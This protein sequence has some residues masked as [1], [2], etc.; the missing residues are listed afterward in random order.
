[1]FVF[2][3]RSLPLELLYV[4]PTLF[5][6]FLEQ[7]QVLVPF[8]PGLLQPAFYYM[9]PHGPDA[10]A[11]DTSLRGFFSPLSFPKI[12]VV[13]PSRL[14]GPLLPNDSLYISFL[15]HEHGWTY[16]QGPICFPVPTPSSRLR[17]VLPGL[18]LLPHPAGHAMKFFP[19][20]F[21]WGFCL[22]ALH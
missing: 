11:T 12:K 3:L 7:T 6:V 8:A 10:F 13:F 18:F 2:F 21:L 4:N 15:M 1:M 19:L 9:F 16:V 20:A 17:P 5:G 14:I 22:R